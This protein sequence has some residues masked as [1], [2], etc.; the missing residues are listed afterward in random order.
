VFLATAPVLFLNAAQGTAA[1]DRR[2]LLMARVYRV[3]RL[4]V[5]RQIILPGIAPYLLAGFSFALGV[6]W[7]VT[8]T[9]E[10]IGSASG[11]G[12]QIYWAYRLLDMPRLF[13]WAFVLIGVGML[14]EVR[15]IRP[16][17][18]KVQHERFD[19]AG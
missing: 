2:L 15:V 10:F 11:V 3:P 18:R 17:R 5:L 19:V 8:S 7:K 14:L 4:T 6:C 16:L 12:A 9:A 13:A 1:L